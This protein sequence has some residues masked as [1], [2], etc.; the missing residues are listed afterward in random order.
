M[1]HE[2]YRG[3][4]VITRFPADD[5]PLLKGLARILTLTETSPASIPGLNGNHLKGTLREKSGADCSVEIILTE[6][7]NETGVMP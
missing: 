4:A 7:R 3:K 5:S 2:K 6:K 1:L